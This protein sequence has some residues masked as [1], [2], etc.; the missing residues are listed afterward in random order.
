METVATGLVAVEMWF[1]ALEVHFC[2]WLMAL[3]TASGHDS[4]EGADDRVE[5]E[6]AQDVALAKKGER[7]VLVDALW[8]RANC[9]IV[10]SETTF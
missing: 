10:W 2:Y 7:P 9:V 8:T 5:A 4:N 3:E 6:E 1:E